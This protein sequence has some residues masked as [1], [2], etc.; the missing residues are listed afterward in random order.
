MNTEASD[1]PHLSNQEQKDD[2]IHSYNRR[3]LDAE[4]GRQG[5]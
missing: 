1:Y 4:G 5:T 3:A 2:G